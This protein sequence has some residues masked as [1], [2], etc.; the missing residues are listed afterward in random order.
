MCLS[1]CAGG[2]SGCF[3]GG[4]AEWEDPRYATMMEAADSVFRLGYVRQAQQQYQAALDRAF[5][6]DDP[7]AIH[8]AGFNLTTSE[9][10]LKDYRS[11]LVTLDRVSA[12]LTTRG[13]IGE[14]QA[15]LHLVRASVLYAQK[16]W[17]D[18]ESEAALARN[19]AD[20]SVRSKAYALTGL[21]AVELSDRATLEDVIN[22]LTASK[23]LS[24]P[25]DLQE[26]LVRR[27]MM[28]Q[29][30]SQAVDEAKKLVSSREEEM[31]YE[32]MRRALLL[33]ARALQAAGQQGAADDVMRRF[34]DSEKA[35]AAQ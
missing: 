18:V 34:T 12:A 9:L 30:W 3:G 13:W 29:T 14:Q 5:L 32:A 8:D 33:E 2:L 10:R 4:H 22:H 24:N 19:S 1:L 25:T 17:Q 6:I 27:S 20:G 7:R 23:K 16:Y 35:Q 15:D 26:L 31:D 11:S 28:D 21:A